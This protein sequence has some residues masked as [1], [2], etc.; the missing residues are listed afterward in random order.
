MLWEILICYGT[1]GLILFCCTIPLLIAKIDKLYIFTFLS[2]AFI[3]LS[4]SI[5]E[6]V[7]YYEQ[8]GFSGPMMS[9]EYVLPL[10]YGTLATVCVSFWLLYIFYQKRFLGKIDR[11][12][13]IVMGALIL[14]TNFVFG[15]LEDFFCWYV[16]HIYYGA[17]AGKNFF[18]IFIIWLEQ[19][20]DI[21]IWLIPTV[22]LLICSFIF[23][24]KV[25]IAGP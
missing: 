25:K 10:W 3:Y 15:A 13:T 1:I 19:K 23:A 12:K 5:W 18:E 14:S 6:M 17:H 8:G 21:A 20:P 9:L 22:P 7:I 11:R 2:I 24:K 4:V 16:D